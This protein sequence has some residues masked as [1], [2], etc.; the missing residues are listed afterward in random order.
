MRFTMEQE[1]FY[2]NRAFRV[3]AIP[4]TLRDSGVFYLKKT[5]EEGYGK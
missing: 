3:V 5:G 1:L 4:G 2:N